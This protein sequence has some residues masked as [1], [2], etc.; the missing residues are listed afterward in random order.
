MLM[1]TNIK[2]NNYTMP[3]STFDTDRARQWVNA[4]N[5]ARLKNSETALTV[6][7]EQAKAEY[8]S[9]INNA[10]ALD[11]LTP[12]TGSG[13]I[14]RITDSAL[15][16]KQKKNGGLALSDCVMRATDVTCYTFNTANLE[17]VEFTDIACGTDNCNSFIS[18]DTSVELTPTR[19]MLYA[20][21]CESLLSKMS[22]VG[23]F[24]RSVEEFMDLKKLKLADKLLIDAII[25][26]ADV[27]AVDP[28]SIQTG[29][30]GLHEA[31]FQIQGQLVE[32]GDMCFAVNGSGLA[33]LRNERGTNGQFISSCGCS[34]IDLSN[35]PAD[36]AQCIVGYFYGYPV[37]LV[38]EIKNT[39]TVDAAGTVTAD[40]GGTSS[41][42]IG[43]S[44][45]SLALA[46]GRRIDDSIQTWSGSD[47]LTLYCQDKYAIACKTS[48]DAKVIQPNC[49][50]Y[51][52]I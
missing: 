37:Y 32:Y 11:G 1:N 19:K 35:E 34:P 50:M 49:V 41:L 3:T 4:I 23:D 42:L 21:V 14:S 38:P 31:M 36:R 7:F 18:T 46:T 5:A 30:G 22:S 52:A 15:Q 33:K 24:L 8:E 28:A 27:V 43:M 47:D 39:Y 45:G 16:I 29:P 10:K 51:Y 26:N 12:T 40:T 9:A 17:T 13:L 25:N 44:Q 2:N 6:D 20:D 48:M